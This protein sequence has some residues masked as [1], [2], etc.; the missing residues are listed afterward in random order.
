M[1]D[2]L[3]LTDNGGVF[4]L[5]TVPLKPTVLILCTGNSYRSHMGEGILRA[6]AGDILDVQSAG[7]NPAGYVH[8]L[9][10]EAMREF[11]IDIIAARG[12]TSS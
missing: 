9:A 10:V 8:S 3:Q 1:I 5:N 7:S 2:A 12:L 11:G 4:E 6:S